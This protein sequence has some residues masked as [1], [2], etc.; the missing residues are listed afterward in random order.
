MIL[1]FDA[2]GYLG[3][4]PCAQTAGGSLTPFQII[5]S[6]MSGIS[7][8]NI[9]GLIIAVLSVRPCTAAV[10]L[11]AI[12]LNVLLCIYSQYPRAARRYITPEL[13]AAPLDIISALTPP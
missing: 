3:P 9:P 13:K 5:F 12:S 11:S 6:V 4:R 8:A 2:I 7:H 1:S 10:L